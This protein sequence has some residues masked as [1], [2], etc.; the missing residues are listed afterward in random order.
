MPP[1]SRV[2]IPEGSFESGTEPGLH[3]R[4]PEL[5]PKTRRVALGPFHIDVDLFPNP[6][7]GPW[8]AASRTQARD[9]CR[10]RGARLC[11]ELEWERACKGPSSTPFA[12]GPESSA[13]CSSAPSG[14]VS[15]FGVRG[16]GSVR[17]WTA[18]DA[19]TG[20]AVGA[21]I[22]GASPTEPAQWRRCAHRAVVDADAGRDVGFRCC[23]GPP[24]A[25]RVEAPRLGATFTQIELPLARLAELLGAD[26]HTR[27]LS[28]ELAYFEPEAARTVLDR[29]PGD[30][31]GFLLTTAPLLWNPVAG[32]DFLVVAARS[33]HKTSFVVAF[34]VLR[35][36]DYRLASS[37]VM[38]GEPGPIVLAYNGY[39][40]PRLH[41]SSCW[42]CPGETGKILYRDPDQ[43]VILQP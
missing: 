25:A 22:R 24:N 10:E 43:A 32:A 28:R 1:G 37:F 33:G 21:V 26:S 20:G 8:M 9:A 38:Q 2:L 27:E 12:W 15:A 39:I 36:N 7:G 30:T 18:S 3:G 17:E 29:G 6:A 14:C 13:E 41:F 11:T 40:R 31:K 4:I 35:D 19:K 23:H 34:H 16:L 42:G 5:E